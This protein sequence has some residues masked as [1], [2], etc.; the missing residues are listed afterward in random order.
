VQ[1]PPREIC[2]ACLEDALEWRSST[3]LPGTVLAGAVL[4]HSFDGAF[5]DRLPLRV[6]L[7]QIGLG[8]VAVCFLDARCRGGEI[9]RVTARLDAGGHAVLTAAPP[10]DAE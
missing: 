6:G 9:L 5:R 3:D 10:G 1:Y 4:H 8:A 2:A 7:V